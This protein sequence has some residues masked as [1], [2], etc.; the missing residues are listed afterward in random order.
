M[1]FRSA[2][3]LRMEDRVLALTSLFQAN[4]DR[5]IARYPRYQELYERYAAAEYN[6]ARALP[7]FQTQDFTD[8]QV[9][10]QLA[11]FDEYALSRH[12]QV[13]AL[14]ERGRNFTLADQKT[15]YA[16]QQALLARIV[17]AYRESSERG[18]VELSTSQIGRAHV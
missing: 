10:S 12:A 14:A 16:R 5:L 1:L 4:P 13:R 7:F 9:L 3:E 15:L 18:Q 8:L 11:W 2:D 6:A 17:P